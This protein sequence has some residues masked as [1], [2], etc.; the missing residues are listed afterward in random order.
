MTTQT[1]EPRTISLSVNPAPRPSSSIPV[2]ALAGNPNSGKTTLFNRLT[3]LRAKTSNFAGTTI[4]HRVGRLALGGCTVDLYDLPGLYGLSG[5]Y[6]EEQVAGDLIR[7]R[8]PG[9]TKPSAVIVVVDA[10]NLPRN[11]YLAGQVRE[12]DVPVVIALNM[13]DLARRAGIKVDLDALGVELGAPVVPI[14]ARSGEGVN[15]LRRV[16]GGL[17]ADHGLP[18][19]PTSTDSS[20]AGDAG[21]GD[22]AGEAIDSDHLRIP[23]RLAACSSCT[24]C[25]HKARFD[26]AEDVH[27]RV[28]GQSDRQSQVRTE[29]IDRFFTHPVFGLVSFAVIAALTFI[30]IFWL[31][32]YPMEMVEDGAEW[33][34][35][36]VASVMPDND[37]GSLVVDG[38]IGG[39]GSVL[40]FLPQICI[41]FFFLTILEDT[42]Y[43]SRAVLVMDRLM[44]KV[45]LPGRAFVPMLSAHA[46]AI[47]AI[48][49]T[50]IIEDRRDRLIT[51]LVL[52]LLTCSARLPVYAMITALLFTGRPVMGGLAFAGAYLLGI[53]AALVTAFV[54]R[55][56]LLKGES[57]PLVVELPG[58]KL[59]S[60]RTALL[61]TWDRA[62]VFLIRAGTVILGISIVLWALSTYPKLDEDQ[63]A[64]FRPAAA[65]QLAELDARIEGAVDDPAVAEELAA[66]RDGIMGSLQSEFSLA[67]RAGRSVEP[68]FNPLGFTWQIN[69]GILSSFAA[70]E[71]FV[72]TLAIVYGADDEEAEDDPDRFRDRLMAQTRD[73]GSP[74]FTTP[75]ALSLLVFF[76][77]AMQCLPTQ[78]VTKRETGSWGWALLQLAYMSVL[79]Y[80]AAWLT[81]TVASAVVG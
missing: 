59:P 2:V 71:V 23:D 79:A 56:S 77:L 74:V 48:M 67:G 19:L 66:E 80:T 73:D 20:P 10:T 3:G 47:P 18:P 38:I 24:G 61:V 11:L 57:R 76:V 37:F 54:L 58:Y 44:R 32:E 35:G 45:G 43:L 9:V 13:T 25:P 8:M 34:S 14:S 26:W 28:A 1:T 4:E 70:R 7:G 49:S 64:D 65:A 33:L 31:A 41:L 69:V 22:G 52:P 27:Q 40:V 51:I 62:K 5:G 6:P 72:S 36:A 60:L 21:A 39:V 81:F 29:H 15:E 46:C 78:V 75:V 12:C 55:L 16:V 63:V 42:G 53:I 50:R 68:I 17:V 30:A